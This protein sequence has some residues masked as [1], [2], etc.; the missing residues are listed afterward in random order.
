MHALVKEFAEPFVSHRF[1]NRFARLPPAFYR[2]VQ[3]TPL[4]N[5]YLV[6]VSEDA[7]A[8]LDLDAATCRNEKFLDLLAGNWL[9]PG[10]EPL[11][12]LYAGHQFGTFVPQLGDGRAI[13]LGE[14]LNQCGER[15]QLQL[16]GAGLTP[17]SRT[18][19]GRAV[20]RSTVREYLCSEAMHALGV[21]TTRALGM[22]GADEPVYRE[23]PETAAVVMRIAPSFVRFGSFE[24]FY[25]RREH[26]RLRQLADH[27][28]EEHYPQC[29]GGPQA[30]EKFLIEVIERTACLIA[31]WQVVGFCHGVMNTDNMS[32]LGLTL[33]YG[34]FGFME[35][36]NPGHICNHS[37]DQGRYS[38]DNQ[39]YIGLWNCSRLAQA[40]T[41]LVDAEKCNAALARYEGVY[42]T[43]YAAHMRAKMG[44]AQAMDGDDALAND[45]LALL[46]EYGT[47]YTIFFRALSTFDLSGNNATL[48]DLMVNREAFDR[49]TVRYAARLN[50]ENSFAAE[51]RLR[52]NRVNP[53]YVLRNHLAQVAIE[54]S[55]KNKDFSEIDRL[56]AVLRRPFDEQPEFDSYAEPPPDWAKDIAVSCSS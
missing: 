40:L 7:A 48:R 23:T 55:S 49:W 31:H 13:L 14:I 53:K 9:P 29:A 3:P 2:R 30:Y 35:A 10:A 45:L 32:I 26:E 24:V 39:P 42:L 44:L 21:P 37:D 19:D 8:L 15:W 47:D 18:A 43:A 34:P 25:A 20:L 41:P 28:I 5:P 52:M 11:A 36:F 22:A 12:M 56:L 50:A 38:Y 27:V 54:K 4:A 6:S 33:D 16:K 51:R 46:A 17:F 1:D